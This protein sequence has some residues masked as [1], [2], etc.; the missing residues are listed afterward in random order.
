MSNFDVAMALNANTAQ[1]LL[2]RGKIVTFTKAGGS[3]T[4]ASPTDI[5]YQFAAA[6]SG[7]PV[8]LGACGRPISPTSEIPALLQRSLS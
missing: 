4:L 6:G 8:A 3:W 1:V 7:S 2:F 5:G